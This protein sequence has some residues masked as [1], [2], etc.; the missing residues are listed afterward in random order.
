MRSLCLLVLVLVGCGEEV[1]EEPVP[2]WLEEEAPVRRLE[3]SAES[4]DRDGD[5]RW[6]LV[7]E[8]SEVSMAERSRFVLYLR[9]TNEGTETLDP[10]LGRGTFFLD[11][12]YNLDLNLW[13][14]NGRRRA[15]WGA[16]PPGE[17]VS[18]QR[19]PGQLFEAPGSFTFAYQHGEAV[20]T[21]T[22]RVIP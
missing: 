13:F 22:V 3:V 16:L 1:A 17:T 19:T 4:T 20:S 7:A 18:D 15:E 9:A 5:V 12:I 21:A 8:P 10:E 14:D 2:E 6:Q 11:G